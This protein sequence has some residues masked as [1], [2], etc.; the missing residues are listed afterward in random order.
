MLKECSITWI[1]DL[2]LAHHLTNNDF[3][4]LVVNL[5]TL[6]TVNVLHLVDDVFLYCGGTL[7]RQDVIGSDDTVRKWCTCTHGVV[8]LNKNLLG[9]RHKILA[10][11]TCLG[12]HDNLSVT[13][14]YLAHGHLTVNLAHHSRVGRVTCLKQLGHTWKTTGDV[15]CLTNG[16]RNLHQGST[17]RNSLTVFHNNVT[18]HGEDICTYHLATLIDDVAGRHLALVL[19]FGDDLLGKTCSII[20]F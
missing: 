18:S 17:C 3:K 7:D 8:F 2:Y 20:G 13:T 11:F 15:T 19:R 1:V 6:Q 16:T 9:Q 10:L 12:S 4:V 14:L 5:H